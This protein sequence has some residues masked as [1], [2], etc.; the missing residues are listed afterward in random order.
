MLMRRLL[1][2]FKKALSG[3]L[4]PSIDIYTDGSHKSGW[5]SW[6][7]VIVKNGIIIHEASGKVRPTSST[8]ME[9]QAAIEAFR[10]LNVR[11]RVRLFSDS[12]I[13]IDSIRPFATKPFMPRAFQDSIMA[14]KKVSHGHDVNWFWIKSHAGHEFNERCDQLCTSAR[15]SV[16][17]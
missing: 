17:P 11:T 1:K 4:T 16:A 10:Y 5:G 13:L 9:Y 6:A 2:D 15:H 14:L 12:K 7:Y 3:V 8:H